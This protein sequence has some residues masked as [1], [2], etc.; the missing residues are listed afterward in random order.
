MDFLFRKVFFQWIS[1]A[2]HSLNPYSMPCLSVVPSR[3]CLGSA[4]MEC[5][6]VNSVIPACVCLGSTDRG[7]WAVGPACVGSQSFGHE[8]VD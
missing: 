6:A 2:V 8:I 7:H 1:D 3:V 5:W 4:D